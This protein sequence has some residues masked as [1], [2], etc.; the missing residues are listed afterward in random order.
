MAPRFHP[1]PTPVPLLSKTG[2]SACRTVGVGV[3]LLLAG[4]AALVLA[5]RRRPDFGTP[6][7]PV[8]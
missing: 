1:P 2:E 8:G 6:L 3:L 4:A 5:R 7:G